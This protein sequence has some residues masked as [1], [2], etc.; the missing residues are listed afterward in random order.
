MQLQFANYGI[1]ANLCSSLATFKNGWR[2]QNYLKAGLDFMICVY[3]VLITLYDKL[4]AVS[5]LSHQ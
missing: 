1:R 2:L 3:V 4:T 5:C